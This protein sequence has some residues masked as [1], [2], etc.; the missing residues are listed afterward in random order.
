MDIRCARAIGA[1]AAAVATGWHAREEL[2]QE[3][4]DLLLDDLDD[5]LPLVG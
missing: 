1:Q 3:S 2:E 5:A 4:P